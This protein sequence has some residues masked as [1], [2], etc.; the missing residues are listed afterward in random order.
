MHV[1]W[2]RRAVAMIVDLPVFRYGDASQ[3]NQG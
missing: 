2:Y 1:V 3:I